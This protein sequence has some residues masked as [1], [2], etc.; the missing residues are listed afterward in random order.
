MNVRAAVASDV[1]AIASVHVLGWRHAYSGILPS[2]FLA[3]L[4]V[5]QRA[6]MWSEALERNVQRLLVVEV[7]GQ[8]AGFVAFGPCR[9][10][11]AHATAFEVWAIYLDPQ[12]I[13]TGAGRALWLG[14]LAALKLAGA[15]RVTLWVLAE[16]TLAIRF[17]RAAG[18]TEEAGSRKSSSV[19][20]VCVDELRYAQSISN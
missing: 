20:G 12:C 9:D 2:D 11:G 8:L 1:D 15:T 17:Y 7:T 13:G 19:G 10:N 5:E 4:S 16:N 3:S 6:H 18:F 14:A